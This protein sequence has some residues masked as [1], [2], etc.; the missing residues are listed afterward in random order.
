VHAP[1]RIN[2]HI[3]LL[4]YV[5]CLNDVMALTC[6]GAYLDS[7]Q[8]DGGKTIIPREIFSVYEIDAPFPSWTVHSSL[9]FGSANKSTFLDFLFEAEIPEKTMFRVLPFALAGRSQAPLDISILAQCSV[10][11]VHEIAGLVDSVPNVRFHITVMAQKSIILSHAAL[12]KLGQCVPRVAELVDFH[13]AIVASEP[14]FYADE[15]LFFVND[16]QSVF[17]AINANPTDAFDS[18]SCSSFL[19]DGPAPV[20][21]VKAKNFV[22]KG[23]PY[24]QNLFRNVDLHFTKSTHAIVLD[25]DF[26]VSENLGDAYLECFNYLREQGHNM[27]RVILIP[28][29]LTC[30]PFQ[31]SLSFIFSL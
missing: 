3:Q 12:K 1:H 21:G 28:P 29:G 20:L 25:S 5:L 8:P 10:D 26:R 27:S 24:P 18:M 30:A 19:L 31:A 4:G 15:N 6:A 2:V 11:K 14:K 9:L 22:D 16:T 23:V 13:L 7:K 17:A